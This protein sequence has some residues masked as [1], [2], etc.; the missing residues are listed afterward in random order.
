MKMRRLRKTDI[1]GGDKTAGL[2]RNATTVIC[3]M[4]KKTAVVGALT[5]Q[6]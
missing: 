3:G 4:P 2:N 1:D 5:M 6:I